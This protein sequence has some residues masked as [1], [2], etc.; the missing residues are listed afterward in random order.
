[1][2]Q[3]G[4]REGPCAPPCQA[5]PSPHPNRQIGSGLLRRDF[6]PPPPPP[7]ETQANCHY[8]TAPSG[9]RLCVCRGEM[10]ATLH[11]GLG[12]PSC[13]ILSSEVK[14]RVP[15]IQDRSALGYLYTP[16]WLG[17]L[18]PWLRPGVLRGREPGAQRP[19]D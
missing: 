5:Q 9:S 11:F 14:L 13:S 10:W 3:V 12:G 4:A 2:R 18:G 7:S 6:H 17:W 1:M 8:V 19:R 16:E 15:R